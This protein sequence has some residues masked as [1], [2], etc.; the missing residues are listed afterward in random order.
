MNVIFCWCTVWKIR[1]RHMA[2]G[3]NDLPHHQHC[4]GDDFS[5]FLLQL[6][7]SF[8]WKPDHNS[9]YL[10]FYEILSFL[11]ETLQM[12]RADKMTK[13]DRRMKTYMQTERRGKMV[14]S[15]CGFLFRF[16]PWMTV[17]DRCKQLRSQELLLL[18]PTTWLIRIAWT[19]S[20]I[21]FTLRFSS[22]RMFVF[23][24]QCVFF[25]FLLRIVTLMF[26]LYFLYSSAAGC[27]V[28]SS[29]NLFVDAWIKER[30]GIQYTHKWT[31]NLVYGVDIGLR[32]LRLFP[33]SPF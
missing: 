1:C 11:C 29:L 27:F 15:V 24:T 23:L 16:S 8:M 14:K 4:F 21:W 26:S 22:F 7:A 28:I 30:R 6:R 32:A 3:I 2:Y 31:H 9:L 25:L 12:N 5:P 18:M 20:S 13:R 33:C 10:N 19:V 17:E